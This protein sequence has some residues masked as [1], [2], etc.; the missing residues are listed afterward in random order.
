MRRLPTISAVVTLAISVICIFGPL[1]YGS[2]GY[3]SGLAVNGPRLIFILSIP[4]VISLLG[5]AS[6]RWLRVVAA[7]SM[8]LW[9]LIAGFSVGLLYTPVAVLMF[10]QSRRGH[11]DFAVVG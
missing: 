9:V 7:I 5:F 2:E 8:L 10:I 3:S 4:V 6:R 11:R 1:Y